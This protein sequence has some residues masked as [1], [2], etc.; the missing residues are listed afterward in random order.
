MAQALRTLRQEEEMKQNQG[1]LDG[2][3]PT[4][5]SSKLGNSPLKH[6]KGNQSPTEKSE[7]TTEAIN[8]ETE[9]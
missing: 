2:S 1:I 3:L 4:K 5:N 7:R 9:E 6:K 8:E